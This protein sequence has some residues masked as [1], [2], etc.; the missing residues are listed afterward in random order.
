MDAR[1]HPVAGAAR[2][3]CSRC[4]GLCCVGLAFD[5]SPSFAFDK[6]AGTPCRHL[7][8]EDRCRRH[9]CLEAEGLG[10]CAR[11]DCGGA[12]Q[13]VSTDL[14][15]GRSWREGPQ[16][17]REMLEAFRALREVVELRALLGAARRLPLGPRYGRTLTALVAALD[18]PGGW[19]PS[20]LA[21]FEDG[22]LP[23]RIRRFLGSLRHQI[24]RPWSGTE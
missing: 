14:F 6:A 3:D 5:R 22:P 10:G 18:R 1:T 8:S 9:A 23:A 16:I 20:A 15:P 4:V 13:Q 21:R 17:A 24:E 2:A 19:S 11:Y 12:G 7:T